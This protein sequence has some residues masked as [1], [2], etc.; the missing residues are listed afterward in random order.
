MVSVGIVFDVNLCLFRF[1][2]GPIVMQ[3]TFP[4]PPMCTSKEL[5]AVLSKHGAEMVTSFL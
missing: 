4:V 3:K 5:E 2:V 1:D